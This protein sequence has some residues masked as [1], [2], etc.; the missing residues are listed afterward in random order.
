MVPQRW[1][2]A[3]AISVEFGVA[4]EQWS[5]PSAEPTVPRSR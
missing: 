4:A 2:D 1:Y 5:C 3:E